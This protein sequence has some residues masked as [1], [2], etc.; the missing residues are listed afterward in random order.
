M[1]LCLHHDPQGYY[2]SGR[3]IGRDGDFITAPEVS[4]LFGKALAA[5]VVAQ[6]RALGRPAAWRLVELGPGRGTLMASLLPQLAASQTP[7]PTVLH[8]V[9]ASPAFQA[10]IRERLNGPLAFV[11]DLGA[12]PPSDLPTLVIGNEYLDALP[13]RQFRRQEGRLY[14]ICVG[15]DTQGQ[16]LAFVRRDASRQPCPLAQDGYWETC[17]PAQAQLQFLASE[18]QVAGGAVLLIDYGYT[19]WPGRPTFQALARHSPV[20]PL[21]T[22]GQADLTALVDFATLAQVVAQAG[23]RPQVESQQ[24]LLL[25]LGFASLLDQAPQET[26]AAAR[27]IR[28]DAMGRLFQALSFAAPIP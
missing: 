7:A 18:I 9:E 15:L 13:V 12:L 25:R 2:V 1:Q 22:P 10:Q 23:L 17:G 6:W 8:L 4:P 28:P 3:G 26:A 11:A 24:A 20:N 16:D 27:L 14:E 19:S 21:A 5:W